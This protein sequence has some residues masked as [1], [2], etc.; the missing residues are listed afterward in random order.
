MSTSATK[1]RE[2]IE[3]YTGDISDPN[4]WRL[5]ARLVD[6]PNDLHCMIHL[7]LDEF[8]S[9]FGINVSD[10]VDVLYPV[11]DHR[12]K[13]H[14][15][16]QLI[17][18]LHAAWVQ[19][20]DIKGLGEFRGQLLSDLRVAV[21]DFIKEGPEYVL[22]NSGPIE[23]VAMIRGNCGHEIVRIVSE[24]R[25]EANMHLPAQA[26]SGNGFPTSTATE[27]IKPSYDERSTQHVVDALPKSRIRRGQSWRNKDAGGTQKKKSPK[28]NRAWD[29]TAKKMATAYIVAC[30]KAGKRIPRLKFIETRLETNPADFPNALAASTINQ[31]LKQHSEKWEH[32]LQ[33][34]IGTTATNDE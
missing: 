16:L 1:I 5:I 34:A 3:E 33:K 9:C 20:Q 26:R 7:L 14:E 18:I 21:H 30:R 25:D 27:E 8:D 22:D 31:A 10:W 12:D 6:R 2:W 28:N 32:R 15:L 17:D 24:L 23:E 19:G 11:F 13:F 4:H 29:A